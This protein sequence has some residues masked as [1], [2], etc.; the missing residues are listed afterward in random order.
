VS[1]RQSPATTG[2]RVRAR[3]LEPLR[4]VKPNGT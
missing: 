1:A 4:A 3:G 2:A